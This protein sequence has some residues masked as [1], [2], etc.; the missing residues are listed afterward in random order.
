[1]LS[2][3][4]FSITLLAVHLDMS[5]VRTDST[6][7]VLVTWFDESVS[8]GSWANVS[9]PVVS[10]TFTDGLKGMTE[11]LEAVYT[12]TLQQT[13]IM[14][15]IRASTLFVAQTNR[16]TVCICLSSSIRLWILVLQNSL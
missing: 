3:S 9:K 8:A 7:E 4:K 14:H 12:Q 5:G 10:R 16:A 11:A 6:R 15:F 1:M 13:C 2:V